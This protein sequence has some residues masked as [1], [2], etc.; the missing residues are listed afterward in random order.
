MSAKSRPKQHSKIL[1]ATPLKSE[2]ETMEEKRREKWE[3]KEAINV[4]KKEKS[5][6]F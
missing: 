2:L 4:P 3:K 5:Q 1:A 6:E